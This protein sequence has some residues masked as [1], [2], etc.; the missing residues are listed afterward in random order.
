MAGSFTTSR[1]M[2]AREVLYHRAAPSDDAQ[3]GLNGELFEI[4]VHDGADLLH[5]G[6][7]LFLDVHL[8]GVAEVGDLPVPEDVEGGLEADGEPVFP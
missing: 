7:D 2:P 1:T 6:I 8:I 5:V 3:V 4:A